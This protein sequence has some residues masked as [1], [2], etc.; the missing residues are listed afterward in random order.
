M[1]QEARNS[2]STHVARSAR[3]LRIIATA[4]DLRQRQI[5]R[6]CVDHLL[7]R[8]RD[9]K[10]ISSHLV[11]GSGGW[12]LR[13][14]TYGFVIQGDLNR[15]PISWALPRTV[16]VRLTWGVGHTGVAGSAM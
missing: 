7:Q 16:V 6:L 5:S 2:V 1:L 8:T 4:D 9:A 12:P 13:Y 11:R 15:R 3:V 10:Y 14:A